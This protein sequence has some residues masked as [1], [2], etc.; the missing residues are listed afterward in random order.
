MTE[1]GGLWVLLG[2]WVTYYHGR[3]TKKKCQIDRESESKQK[4]MKKAREKVGKMSERSRAPCHLLAGS[5]V[6]LP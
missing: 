6:L 2:G 3:T 1:G 5:L 4:G